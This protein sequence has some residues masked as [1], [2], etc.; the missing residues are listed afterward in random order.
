MYIASRAAAAI[1]TS[2]NIV[3]I[4]TFSFLN[5]LLSYIIFFVC[6]NISLFPFDDAKVRTICDMASAERPLSTEKGPFVDLSQPFPPII[7]LYQ[8]C[9]KIRIKQDEL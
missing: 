8:R 3:N 5:L 4:I 2:E 9:K 1:T 6:R 7:D